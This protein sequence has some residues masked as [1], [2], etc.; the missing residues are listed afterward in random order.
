LTRIY[1]IR[2]VGLGLLAIRFAFV[3][4]LF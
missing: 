4:K 2:H 3:D 1:D